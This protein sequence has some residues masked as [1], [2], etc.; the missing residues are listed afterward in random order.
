M[1]PSKKLY[2][3]PT[4]SRLLGQAG[5]LMKLLSQTQAKGIDSTL[6]CREFETWVEVRLNVCLNLLISLWPANHAPKGET[7]FLDLNLGSGC[8]SLG[9]YLDQKTLPITLANVFGY[10]YAVMTAIIVAP[11]SLGPN[12]KAIPHSTS[13]V[14]KLP[15][16]LYLCRHFVIVSFFVICF[17]PLCTYIILII[18]K[19]SKGRRNVMSRIN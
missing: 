13:M 6:L 17:N 19:H 12:S 8:C 4:H 9:F 5:K 18:C 10:S 14:T 1:Y 16:Y 3:G 11:I 7:S 2:L 15:I